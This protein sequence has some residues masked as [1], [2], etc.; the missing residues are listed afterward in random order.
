ME[1]LIRDSRF[2]LVIGTQD[3]KDRFDGRKGGAG[4]EGH[5]ISGDVLNGS[6]GDKFI[7]V[8]R[9][10]DW[11]TSIPTALTAV[12][13]VD[14][15]GNPYIEDEYRK[16]LLKL[17]NVEEE[18]PP[19]GSP[20]EWLKLSAKDHSAEKL[21]AEYFREVN[22]WSV[23]PIDR[24]PVEFFKA[25]MSSILG[26][27]SWPLSLY[28]YRHTEGDRFVSRKVLPSGFRADYK[29]QDPLINR[30]E[31]CEVTNPGRVI[32]RE[33]QEFPSRHR[34]GGFPY[35]AAIGTTAEVLQFAARFFRALGLDES[36]EI[37]VQISWNGLEGKFITADTVRMFSAYHEMKSTI[38]EVSSRVVQFRLADAEMLLVK[39]THKLVGHVFSLFDMFDPAPQL[40][41]EIIQNW[42]NFIAG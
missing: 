25:G 29:Q 2:V 28:W 8:L 23:K 13:G 38:G 27:V 3:Y 12:A 5:I 14:M 4:Y 40:F 21:Q 10:G 36:N 35:D 17:H 34:D 16:L 20:P 18:P 7:P 41:G 15:R 9:S 26:E 31:S 22:I 24:T 1:A 33:T 19:L 37:A 39:N 6:G 11:T 32:I 42:K 30:W